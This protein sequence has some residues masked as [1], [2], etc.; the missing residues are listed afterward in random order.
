MM[1]A[2]LL[3]PADVRG[4]FL[5]A[6]PFQRLEAATAEPRHGSAVPLS[7]RHHHRRKLAH[8]VERAVLEPPGY[9][10]QR[11]RSLRL[12]LRDLQRKPLSVSLVQQR[13][14]AVVRIPRFFGVVG[15]PVGYHGARGPP[16]LHLG[17]VDFPEA[18]TSV[19]DDHN[20][21]LPHI[22]RILVAR[23]D[24][25]QIGA[26]P[27]ALLCRLQRQRFNAVHAALCHRM[28][29]LGLRTVELVQRAAGP[30]YWTPVYWTL[31]ESKQLFRVE[32][33]R[34]VNQLRNPAPAHEKLGRAG[35]PLREML[36]RLG[37]GVPQPPGLRQQR[38]L[39]LQVVN[40]PLLALLLLHLIILVCI[41]L[42]WIID[43]FI[44]EFTRL[45]HLTTQCRR[46]PT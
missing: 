14:D 12:R 18:L 3:I 29:V 34:G 16:Q 36:D 25:Q 11:L 39:Q 40:N 22:L 13:L 8:H 26:C 6:G 33:R 17:S 5:H 7:R 1:P 19:K 20:Q 24:V 10:V 42:P 31:A 38:P 46:F 45:F 23:Q 9:F 32:H 44:D 21:M 35:A 28:P 2:H 30:F 4:V 27:E 43:G 15:W 41:Y 37:A